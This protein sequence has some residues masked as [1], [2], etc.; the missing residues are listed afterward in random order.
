[1]TP[2][3]SALYVA[4]DGNR[5]HT[6]DASRASKQGVWSDVESQDGLPCVFAMAAVAVR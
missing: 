1:M 4:S 3:R 6:T 5:T 2:L